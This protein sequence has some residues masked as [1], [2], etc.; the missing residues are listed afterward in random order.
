M[1]QRANLFVIEDGRCELYYSHWAANRLDCELFWGPAIATAFARRQRSESEGAEL[2]DEVWAEGGAIIDHAAR[3]ILWYGGQNVMHDIP[4]RRILLRMMRSLWSGWSV[5]WAAEGIVD[6][7]DYLGIER[8]RVLCEAPEDSPSCSELLAESQDPSWISTAISSKHDGVCYFFAIDERIDFLLLDAHRLLEEL[9]NRT[10]AQ[11][12]DWAARSSDFPTGGLHVD[13]DS[14]SIGYWFAAEAPAIGVR[15][16]AAL[17]DWSVKCWDD[18]Y[19]SHLAAAP[20]LQLPLPDEAALTQQI[21]DALLRESSDHSDRV[22]ETV[23]LLGERVTNINPF[24]LR[25]DP[26]N[27]SSAERRSLLRRHFPTLLG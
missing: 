12:F 14:R 15:T 7:A 4:R 26:S 21:L 23:A 24:A 6:L 22:P 13:W 27:L 9:R 11:R 1:G 18:H 19:E 2:L 17:P 16:V 10:G 25:D 8:A 5:R 3:M 20:G